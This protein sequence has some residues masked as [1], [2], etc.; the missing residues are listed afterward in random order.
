MEF[1]RM[2]RLSLAGL[3]AL[4]AVSSASA[5]GPPLTGR[6][7]TPVDNSVVEIAAC[8]AALC[9][10]LL[11]SD[12][13][14]A[15]PGRVDEHNRDPRLRHRPLRGLL[16]IS[17]LTPAVGAEARGSIYNPA[18]G[19]TYEARLSLKDADRLEVKGCALKVICKAQTWVRL[20]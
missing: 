18:D 5:G 1:N 14:R 12:R 20:P 16:L 6:W 13:L 15:D 19:A 9:G 11:A 8:G 4:T 10:R 2:R 17:G 3:L 7:R